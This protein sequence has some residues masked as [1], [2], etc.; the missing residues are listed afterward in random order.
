MEENKDNT[1]KNIIEEIEHNSIVMFYLDQKGRV[2]VLSSGNLSKKQK[3]ISERMLTSIEPS[4]I[5]SL[6]FLVEISII[7]F[8]EFINRIITRRA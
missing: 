7:K 1:L 8:Q 3:K 2:T 4:I 5:L 6:V